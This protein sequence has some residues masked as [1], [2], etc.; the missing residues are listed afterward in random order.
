M[1]EDARDPRVDPCP[2][3]RVGQRRVVYVTIH[4]TIIYDY[5]GTTTRERHCELESWRR[6]AKD[7]SVVEKRRKPE[8]DVVDHTVHLSQSA[9]FQVNGLANKWI[10]TLEKGVSTPWDETFDAIFELGLERAI[11]ITGRRELFE[12]LDVRVKRSQ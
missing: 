5:E 2:G 4:K 8:E 3:D 12:A 7:H 1:L 11:T 10:G 6:W 9:F